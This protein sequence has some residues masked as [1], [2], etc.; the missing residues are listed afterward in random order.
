MGRTSRKT[1]VMS[2]FLAML[3]VFNLFVPITDVF[4][5]GPYGETMPPYSSQYPNTIIVS[6]NNQFIAFQT[7]SDIFYAADVGYVMINDKKPVRK[8]VWK[9]NNW[10]VDG[11]NGV[12][13]VGDSELIRTDAGPENGKFNLYSIT[14]DKETV[15][16]QERFKTY[17]II[18]D[19]NVTIINYNSI[20]E[21]TASTS[22][23]SDLDIANWG[24]SLMPS[25]YSL[26]GLAS[27]DNLNSIK[28]RFTLVRSYQIGE[29]VFNIDWQD[30]KGLSFTNSAD[31]NSPIIV[32]VDRSFDADISTKL[33]FNVS[34]NGAT[35]ATESI[36]IRIPKINHTTKDEWV[37]SLNISNYFVF[38]PGSDTNQEN[39]FNNV[40]QRF[41]IKQSA[42]KTSITKVEVLGTDDCLKP[43]VLEN[44]NWIVG[45]NNPSS[46]IIQQVLRITL[47]SND[48]ATFTKIID[49][50][51]L[52]E[53]NCVDIP[54]IS[55]LKAA[56]AFSLSSFTPLKMAR[57]ADD[58]APF[59]LGVYSKNGSNLVAEA[60]WTG[61]GF[62]FDE[63]P[64]TQSNEY[65][66]KAYEFVD[67]I[68]F[69]TMTFSKQTTTDSSKI[70]VWN[71]SQY[72][73]GV[74]T[75]YQPGTYNSNGTNN[76]G[77]KVNNSAYF[78]ITANVFANDTLTQKFNVSWSNNLYVTYDK[79][80]SAA[81]GDPSVI[82]IAR[83]TQ[84]SQL[85]SQNIPTVIRQHYTFEGWKDGSGVTYT[86]TTKV[87]KDAVL[88]A[89]WKPVDYTIT[90]D[91][92]GGTGV[93]SPIT[94][95]YD[96][97]I[98]L[99]D[100]TGLSKKNHTFQG[101][102]TTD[103]VKYVG[104]A[105]LKVS[106]NLELK[107]IWNE[108]E[109]FEITYKSDST[110]DAQV[111]S[112]GKVYINDKYNLLACDFTKYGYTF[113]GWL[114]D[115]DKKV[116]GASTE[117]T[118]GNA[119][120]TYTAT[121]KASKV[122]VNFDANGVDTVSGLPPVEANFGDTI[123]LPNGSVF[124]PTPSKTFLG[125][126]KDKNAVTPEFTTT[127]NINSLDGN[128]LYAVWSTT[129]KTTSF[130]S[131]A[132]SPLAVNGD[133]IK[134]SN[135]TVEINFVDKM[136]STKQNSTQLNL[137]TN[138]I[139]VSNDNLLKMTLGNLTKIKDIVGE[140]ST[141]FATLKISND[142]YVTDMKDV[143]A[144]VSRTSDA[145]NVYYVGT[146]DDVSKKFTPS[147][148]ISNPVAL[149]F[150][151]GKAEIAI[152]DMARGTTKNLVFFVENTKNVSPTEGLSFGVTSKY[153][154]KVW[155][156][157]L[158][159][160][161]NKELKCDLGTISVDIKN[162]TPKI[163]TQKIT[164][165]L[166]ISKIAS[167]LSGEATDPSLKMDE[168][169]LDMGDLLNSN[170]Y[171]SDL[172]NYRSSTYYLVYITNPNNS[173]TKTAETNVSVSP[174]AGVK[175]EFVGYVT[176]DEN[177]NF[178]KT[179]PST[180]VNFGIINEQSVPDRF[181]VL[182]V[183]SNK[184]PSDGGVSFSLALNGQTVLD[185]TPNSMT[186]KANESKADFTIK[187]NPFNQFVAF[188]S[189]MIDSNDNFLRNGGVIQ[190]VKSEEND[191]LFVSMT[192][193]DSLNEIMNPVTLKN[194]YM[195]TSITWQAKV[196]QGDGS[197]KINSTK[198]AI[199]EVLRGSKDTFVELTG[200]ITYLG[201]LA[202]IKIPI[203]IPAKEFYGAS[204]DEIAN[205]TDNIGAYVKTDKGYVVSTNQPIIGSSAPSNV[206]FKF[207]VDPSYL[208]AYTVF[209]TSTRISS[210]NGWAVPFVG[211]QYK[212]MLSE[213]NSSL[214]IGSSISNN[215][216]TV[217]HNVTN[218]TTSYIIKSNNKNTNTVSVSFDKSLAF[219]KK[220]G[221]IY[222]YASYQTSTLF[223]GKYPTPPDVDSTTGIPNGN[224]I[225]LNMGEKVLYLNSSA[226][227]KKLDGGFAPS[228]QATI[229]IY[230]APDW[231]LLTTLENV[232]PASVFGNYTNTSLES[233]L[234][235][236]NK[237]ITHKGE[238]GKEV[239]DIP[240]NISTEKVRIFRA[241]AK[242]GADNYYMI[243]DLVY[244]AYQMGSNEATDSVS[245]YNANSD[246]WTQWFTMNGIGISRSSLPSLRVLNNEKEVNFLGSVPIA[247]ISI[248]V[249]TDVLRGERSDYDIFGT[250]FNGIRLVLHD[251]KEER[252]DSDGNFYFYFKNPI[253]YVM[254]GFSWQ[255]IDVE[256]DNLIGN[257]VENINNV[258]SKYNNA[259]AKYL[260]I[261]SYN[262]STGGSEAKNITFLDVNENSFPN[263]PKPPVSG[264]SIMIYDGQ[265]KI[266]TSKE[267]IYVDTDSE[268]L[269]TQKSVQLSATIF[270]KNGWET[271]VK[272]NKTIV[273]VDGRA[274]LGIMASELIW[275]NADIVTSSNY[276]AIK[277][278][279]T[280]AFSTTSNGFINLPTVTPATS[281]KYYIWDKANPLNY[282]IMRLDA[283]GATVPINKPTA[284]G[285][286]TVADNAKV[287][288]DGVWS[289]NKFT[290]NFFVPN[291]SISAQF[292][293]VIADKKTSAQSESKFSVRDANKYET[294]IKDN[295]WFDTT[296]LQ[297]DKTPPVVDY[298]YMYFKN[299]VWKGHDV[300]VVDDKGVQ[301]EVLSGLNSK[302]PYG[303]EFLSDFKIGSEVH[304][305]KLNVVT[306]AYGNKTYEFV[307]ASYSLYDANGKNTVIPSGTKLWFPY[308]SI[309]I[310]N[311]SED[312]GLNETDFNLYL[313]DDNYNI[314]EPMKA[315]ILKDEDHKVIGGDVPQDILD[316]IHGET[317]DTTVDIDPPVVEYIYMYRGSLYIVGEDISVN[318]RDVSGLAPYPYVV[319][320]SMDRNVIVDGNESRNGDGV[321][322]KTITKDKKT[323]LVSGVVPI[324]EIVTAFDVNVSL[325]DAAKVEPSA[326]GNTSTPIKLTLDKF[327]NNTVLYGNPPEYIKQMLEKEHGMDP[328]PGIDTIPPVIKAVYVSKQKD[329]AILGVI[330]EDNSGRPC[331]YKYDL[332]ESGL[333]DWSS[334][335]TVGLR[336]GDT[337]VARIYVRDNSKN[338]A[339][340]TVFVNTNN[341]EIIYGN[342]SDV[343]QDILDNM[344]L[345]KKDKVPP[346]ITS[347]YVYKGKVYV[348]GYD[349]VSLH[350]S[351]YGWKPM[352]DMIIYSDFVGTTIDGQ[353]I[354]ISAGSIIKNGL[355]IYNGTNSQ[356]IQIP[357]SI[358]VSLRDASGNITSKSFFVSKDN[359][360]L[361]G[362]PPAGLEDILDGA[363]KDDT[364]KDL[365]SE[366]ENKLNVGMHKDFNSI[367]WDKNDYRVQVFD[368]SGRLIYS[369]IVD[370][371]GNV[372]V[373]NISTGEEIIIIES[374]IDESSQEEVMSKKIEYTSTDKIPPVITKV[375]VQSGK[376]YVNATDNVALADAPYSFTIENTR[377]S[378]ER[379][380][381]E[382][383]KKVLDG[384]SVIV[385][386]VDKAGNSASITVQISG[387]KEIIKTV[388][389][390]QPLVF[391]YGDTKSISE[392]E[393]YLRTLYSIDSQYKLYRKDDNSV[394]TMMNIGTQDAS[395][396]GSGSGVI[397]LKKDDNSPLIHV[398]IKVIDNGKSGRTAIVQK[399]S[400]T[401]FM[402]FFKQTFMESFGSMNGVSWQ[403]DKDSRG[404]SKEGEFVVA[405][406]VGVYKVTAV[407]GDE[408]L[409]FYFL[410]QD[411]I[412]KTPS[413]MTLDTD[414]QKYT[415]VVGTKLNF[416]DIFEVPSGSD[417]K[418]LSKYLVV[419]KISDGVTR[420]DDNISITTKGRK[421]ISFLDLVTDTSYVLQF[422]AVELTPWI[423]SYTDISDSFARDSISLLAQVG[424]LEKSSDNKFKP[425]N[426]VSIKEFISD[427]NRIYLAL[428]CD[429]D[430]TKTDGATTLSRK[431]WDFYAVMN[432][433]GIVSS[434]TLTSVIGE[435]A[436][437]TSPVTR[438]Q[439]A[440]LLSNS[441]LMN[442][443]HRIIATNGL[444]DVSDSKVQN[445][446]E[447]LAS[448]GIVDISSGKFRPND[449]LTR[450]EMAKML[451]EAVKYIR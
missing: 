140:S 245:F 295:Q 235:Y 277:G 154:Q 29:L 172:D 122:T 264:Q 23:S 43:M 319:T 424:A 107:A 265:Y 41:T 275:N 190:A 224:V 17:K 361:E 249:V 128:T 432:F 163:Q 100:G 68:D 81:E 299:I 438:G 187:S 345:E 46:N 110:P 148:N 125:W 204:A 37:N 366:S 116:Y 242:D 244:M 3:M 255:R 247:N 403:I 225:V 276:A 246:A 55:L 92:N 67:N 328:T 171:Q 422:E 162:S 181:F 263:L 369:V 203:R 324:G 15:S 201:A 237:D 199:T 174:A 233:G 124:V 333:I 372:V 293:K 69:D 260:Q 309:D 447:H 202:E 257:E 382:N 273:A 216:L 51:L 428:N 290:V 82:E 370:I 7:T 97:T 70:D 385:K 388:N 156:I 387:N 411:D 303:V 119:D 112:G 104:G 52:I 206:N 441:I 352:E 217:Q 131:R 232:D 408:T 301:L 178:A 285:D 39:G 325:I 377:N 239:V 240:A 421:S 262:K 157:D 143:K 312:G 354:N 278:K 248:P 443:P 223:L 266:Y 191:N 442:E 282:F 101:W 414:K 219:A 431:D 210:N 294:N 182:R 231:D 375:Y 420:K 450:Q 177:L 259:R 63:F 417:V 400:M 429:V 283:E 339:S 284:S 76:F 298:A 6:D 1:K 373:P 4:A 127:Y 306:D 85:N 376:L 159:K 430:Y 139:I 40:T 419:E 286:I 222:K 176:N 427:I 220:D 396:I 96:S 401:N 133:R 221:E 384:D 314:S 186:E 175:A 410:V 120:E 8:M 234:L 89:Q 252:K 90:F 168:F 435:K 98:I 346:V 374:V 391:R 75:L 304:A 386:V 165:S 84:N 56:K 109:K 117:M 95:A 62:L 326:N 393:S 50:P 229:K 383:S 147:V 349:N 28:N 338:E 103:G 141:Q 198:N 211:T 407:K 30:T 25:P 205:G 167:I 448:L 292:A 19:N 291:F 329:G 83:I 305:Y 11:V 129:V 93:V 253:E 94:S 258:T 353:P 151:S 390:S 36:D 78:R 142:S 315:K 256:E 371:G 123:S 53:A 416:K 415:Y 145:L 227:W 297:E 26:I 296:S 137:T 359:S 146:Y 409:D 59:K 412:S 45:V 318:G 106:G 121:W 130:M 418:T 348:T 118:M 38:A 280:T 193:G 398:V 212:L 22:A 289:N 215:N 13:T 170:V 108:D 160:T 66:L 99:P 440:V 44:G 272:D 16:G 316:K 341:S 433:M 340:V 194:S 49:V 254:K 251:G 126:A 397:E 195:G 270:G 395:I 423:G 425:L 355:G 337:G 323:F 138:E 33:K 302:A 331:E 61:T 114:K 449:E 281:G 2:M 378:S 347:V 367:D 77:D 446:V 342:E 183:A 404:I 356:E 439:A 330:A 132:A 185:T 241:P 274:S 311:Y 105:E 200:T 308:G 362:T 115:S 288:E 155:G 65:L 111:K 173:K 437:L 189:S 180:S 113:N 179:T 322:I 144:L 197:V 267:Q 250:E 317:G 213:D 238:D 42:F 14:K 54:D 214:P 158:E 327:S 60:S 72:V 405:N 196:L 91:A 413:S 279:G 10:V 150:T 392:W 307:E 444:T 9:N 164:Q 32:D 228:S 134:D 135:Y 73:D 321:S 74:L 269:Y 358:E 268:E 343:P 320:S 351:P 350:K 184:E 64:S 357:M 313:M 88:Y 406:S 230:A 399:N 102:E 365:V 287:S 271:S 300:K 208:G 153:T 310:W 402:L 261:Y 389:P 169:V 58:G 236:T 35:T 24:L 80:F 451:G 363:K 192:T 207:A 161:Y 336:T 5:A 434:D 335:D 364:T 381:T 344:G 243:N 21:S 218:F 332:R 166:Q 334:K 209:V 436:L 426:P 136:F 379:F 86:E 18:S 152:G 47:Q 27:G 71:G 368:K 12:Y 188:I 34:Y 394:N 87:T 79:G 380:I 57:S 226:A 360:L 149:N 48:D 445:A 31:K 20:S